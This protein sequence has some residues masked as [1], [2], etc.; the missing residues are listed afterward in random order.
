MLGLI[1]YGTKG[2]ETVVK[3][4]RFYCPSCGPDIRYQLKEVRR[5]FTL[6]FIPLI[7]LDRIEDDVLVTANGADVLS[8]ALVKEPDAIEALMGH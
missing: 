5:Y 3:S 1:I 8:K 4:G 2:R 7:P 6:Y